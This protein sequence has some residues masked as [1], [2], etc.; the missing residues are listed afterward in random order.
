VVIRYLLER[1]RGGMWPS[2]FARSPLVFPGIRVNFSSSN[3]T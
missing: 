2:L 3:G 1:L